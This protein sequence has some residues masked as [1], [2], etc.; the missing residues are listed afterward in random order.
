[1]A[2]ERNDILDGDEGSADDTAEAQRAA[3]KLELETLRAKSHQ[4]E[5]ARVRA[6]AE[7]ETTRKLS[8]VAAQPQQVNWSDEQWEAEATKYGMT[9]PQMKVSVAIAANAADQRAKALEDKIKAADDR[10]AKAEERFSR[11]E[12]GQGYNTQLNKFIDAKPALRPYRD[13][14]E[15]YLNK[16]PEADRKDPAKLKDL[17]ADAEI[18]IR[19]KVGSKM[20][21]SGN[22]SSAKL[23]GG[24]DEEDNSGEDRIDLSGIEKKSERRVLEDIWDEVKGNPDMKEVDKYLSADKSTMRFDAEAEFKAGDKALLG[25]GTFGGKK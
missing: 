24:F 13:D 10:A 8:A 5:L 22:G 2:I 9:G 23:N 14:V 12:S 15:T 4:D 20:R 3:E 16:F 7:L 1:M 19:G 18:Y 6:E 21:T 25:G 11:L 17:M